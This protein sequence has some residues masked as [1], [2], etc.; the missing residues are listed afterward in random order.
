MGN[1]QSIVKYLR[2][3]VLRKENDILKCGFLS[4]VMPSN[5]GTYNR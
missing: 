3:C 4:H 2:K 1:K 5:D